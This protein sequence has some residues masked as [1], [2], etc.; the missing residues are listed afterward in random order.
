MAGVWIKMCIGLR[1]H[2]KVFRMAS[3]LKVDKLRVIGGL[4]AVWCIFDEH[5]VDGLLEGYS[6]AII[7]EELHWKG[8]AK[9]MQ[10]IGWL[11]VTDDGLTMPDFDAHNGQ[12]AKRRGT[13]AKRKKVSRKPDGSANSGGTKS[14]Q[15]SASDADKQADHLRTREEKRREIPSEAKA[16]GA[17]A[18][19]AP[20]DVIFALGVPLLTAA[21]V[22]DRNARTMLGFMRKHHGDQAVVDALNACA[23]ERPTEPVAWL[24]GALKT[25]TKPANRQ[26]AIE[27]EN[28]RVAQAWAGSV[29]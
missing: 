11:V 8:F 1:S 22:S 10:A 9:A 20:V 13:D 24:Q 7:D 15:M 5:T 29:Q 3:A 25:A 4:F 28:R 16:S 26:I 21:N 23:K 27:D 18:P 12:S 19:P 2:P 14:G 6:P 17:S